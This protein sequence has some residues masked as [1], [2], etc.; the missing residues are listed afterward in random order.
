MTRLTNYYNNL[1]AD[2][3]KPELISHEPA[4]KLLGYAETYIS[5]YKPKAKT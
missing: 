1:S 2:Y 5:L 4:V 3:S